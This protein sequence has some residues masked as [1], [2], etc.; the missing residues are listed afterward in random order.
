MSKSVHQHT[1]VGADGRMA[2]AVRAWKG[3]VAPPPAVLKPGPQTVETEREEWCPEVLDTMGNLGAF[4]GNTGEQLKV[5]NSDSW[6]IV[7]QHLCL[8][9]CYYCKFSQCE[10]G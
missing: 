2:A 1:G 9:Q 7:Q 10:N 5:S 3:G 6:R 8:V 4:L